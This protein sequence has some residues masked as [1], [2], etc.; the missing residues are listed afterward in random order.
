MKGR[1]TGAVVALALYACGDDGANPPDGGAVDATTPD[2]AGCPRTPVARTVHKVVVSH[3]YDAS[4]GA[5]NRYRVLD[6]GRAGGLTDT[7]V[8]FEMGR[9]LI[10]EMAFTP[11]GEVGIVPQ[12]DGTLGVVRFDGDTPVVVHAAF[13]GGFY[14]DRVVIA[15][16]GDLAYVLDNQWR[17][18]GGGVHR[19]AIG[20]DGTLTDL[21]RWI[22]SKLPA[23]LLLDPERALL[24]AND[25]GASPPGDDVHLL[26]W[27]QPVPGPVDGADAFGD[28]EAIVGGT[29]L[30]PDHRFVLIGDTSAFSGVPNRVA[31]AE[32]DRARDTV[33]PVQV[34]SPVEDPL[35]IVVSPSADVALVVSGFGDAVLVLD[36]DPGAVPP[37]TLRG[38]PTYLGASPQLPGHAVLIGTTVL[39]A[40]LEGVRRFRLDGGGVVTDLGLTSL[41]ADTDA[42]TGAIGVQP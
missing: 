34:I 26:D 3:P 41:G 19:V 29:A 36:H 13:A 22:E 30:T 28:D 18:N 21:G 5:A 27:S 25:V 37:F 33:T 16:G 38:E 31:I 12:D 7:G 11:D 14:A 15:P 32:V 24:I 2:A 39:L 8:T 42:I 9:S 17:E 23:G 40:E 10:G 4:G 6:L 20:C 1:A 35:S